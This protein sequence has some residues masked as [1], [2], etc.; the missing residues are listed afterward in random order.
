MV[1]PVRDDF[2]SSVLNSYWNTLL[3]GTGTHD[4]ENSALRCVL[5]PVPK[6]QYSDS[7]ISDYKP[8]PFRWQPPLRLTVRAWASHPSKELKGT[9]GFGF[10]NEPFVPI[11]RQL[12]RLPRTV[13][14]FFGSPPN[15]MA[16]AKGVPG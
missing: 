8:E 4:F 12:P 2:D 11:G 15:N 10:W 3:V 13:W 7:Q 16:L 1:N 5:D 9:A 6:K 14:F